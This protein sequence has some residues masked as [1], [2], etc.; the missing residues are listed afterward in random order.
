[1]TA[2]NGAGGEVAAVQ[3]EPNGAAGGEVAAVRGQPNGAG[4]EVAEVR[5]R[6]TASKAGSGVGGAG[7]GTG[8][9]AIAESIGPTT[10]W[11]AILL[12]AA[13]VASVLIGSGLYFVQLQTNRY[14]Q[15]RVAKGAVNTL[16][17]LLK[18]PQ[19]S[20]AHKA[21]IRRQLEEI[22]SVVARNEVERVKEIGVLPARAKQQ[23]EES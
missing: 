7:A 23:Y 8:L 15:G 1:M 5:G 13:P 6:P 17:K 16:T 4:G 10:T 12:Y 22:E 20:D 11:G 3:G 21:Q 9:V 19:T 18:N 14:L 2:P